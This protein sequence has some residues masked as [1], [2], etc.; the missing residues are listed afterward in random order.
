M[1]IT[2]EP[3]ENEMTVV[4]LERNN[5]AAMKTAHLTCYEATLVGSPGPLLSVLTYTVHLWFWSHLM[6]S[7]PQLTLACIEKINWKFLFHV[8]KNISLNNVRV[9]LVTRKLFPLFVIRA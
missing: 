6:P 2:S 5:I 3:Y 4:V 1:D 9:C 8:V 7:N